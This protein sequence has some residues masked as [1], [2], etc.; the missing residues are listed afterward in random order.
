MKRLEAVHDFV[1][2][3]RRLSF[4]AAARDLAIDASLLSRRISALEEKLG[5][6]LLQRTT[7]VVTLTEAGHLFFERCLDIL[8]R[9]DDAEATISRYSTQASGRLRVAVPT[10]FGQLWIAPFVSGF[11]DHHPGL[12]LDMTFSDRFIDLVETGFDCAIR[13]GALDGGGDYVAKRLA[14]NDRLLCASPEY[15]QNFG[16]PQTLAELQNHRCLHFSPLL[17]GHSWQFV[18]DRKTQDVKIDPWLTSDNAE[19]LRQA[20]VGGLGITLLATFIAAP[21]LRSGRLVPVLPDWQPAQS[22]IYAIYPNA[23][24]LPQ[25]VRVFVDYIAEKFRGTPPWEKS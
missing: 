8:A 3:A 1:A 25:K 13:I 19:M 11:C 5:V 14:A 10:L 23:P 4:A 16:V 20:A 6:R 7:R 24:F 9:L 18:R 12:K 15:L 17:T 2:V 22:A 21:D